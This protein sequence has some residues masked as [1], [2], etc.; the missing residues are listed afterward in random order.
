[1]RYGVTVPNIGELDRL[2][3]MGREAEAAGW[4][5]FFL[6]DH[7]RF[8]DVFAVPVHDPW[9]ALAALAATTSRIRLG[10]MVTPVARRRPWKLARE[11]VTLDHLSHGRLILGAGLGFPPDV[12]FG[13][14]GEPTGARERAE[15][16]DEGLTI[17]DRL[18]SGEPATFHGRHHTIEEV[19]FLPR[20]VQRPRIPVWIAGMWP[21]RAPFRRA[22]RWDGVA[23]GSLNVAFGEAIPPDE[24][25]E[26]LAYIHEYRERPEPFDVAVRGFTPGDN[27][28]RARYQLDPYMAAG[29]TWWLESI[30]GRRGPFD[31]MRERIRQGPLRSA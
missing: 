7:I 31:A 17:L 22:A 1:M 8:S 25:R 23:P 16:L 15:L 27:A 5:G 11:T 6:W 10:P 21:N 12:E 13:S 9:V 3:T 14:F 29:V 19:T 28:E 30:N 4:D 26:L 18:W 20:P 2:L 24:L